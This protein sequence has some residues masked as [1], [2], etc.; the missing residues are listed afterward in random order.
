MSRGLGYVERG[1]LE[2]L[3]RSAYRITPLQAAG[4]LLGDEATVSDKVAS[5]ARLPPYPSVAARVQ[6]TAEHI[7]Q[8]TGIFGVNY[9]VRHRSPGSTVCHNNGF[10]PIF[11]GVSR[12]ADLL[13]KIRSLCHLLQI[14]DTRPRLS[15]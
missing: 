5:R 4:A 10:T 6:L 8:R 15:L 3:D 14:P 13:T 12:W 2:L 7:Y 9:D 1:L 11:L